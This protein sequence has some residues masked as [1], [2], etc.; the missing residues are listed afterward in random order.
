MWI[1]AKKLAKQ[2]SAF[3][4]VEL[5]LV[6]GT[7]AVV[8]GALV[9]L[10]SNSYEDWK[11]GSNRSTLLQDGQAT[12]EQMVRILRQAKGFSAV[13][14]PTDTAG[15]ITFIDVDG[16]L[17][18]FRLANSTNELQYGEPASLSTLAGSVSSLVF[19]SYD[20]DANS[21][22]DPVQARKIR[23]VHITTTLVDPDN[24]SLM[25]TLSGMVFCQEDFLNDIAINEIMYNPPGGGDAP[26][27][28]V[29]IYNLGDSVVDT[30]GWSINGDTL[31]SHS[32]FGDGSTTIPA[33]GYAVITSSTTNIYTELI[34]NGGF[35][36]ILK[37]YWQV[38]NWSRTKFNAH[39]GSYKLES[40]VSGAAWVYQDI[41]I[42]T[43][44][45][46]YL[47]LF[48]ERTTSAIAQTQIT[49]TVRNLS[50]VI[51][52]TGYGG[53]MNS[54]W[55]CH[56]MDISAFAGQTVRIY[57]STTNNGSGSLLLDDVSVAYS[58]VDINATRL[59]TGDGQ[60]GSGLSDSTDTVTVSSGSSTVD[61][62]TYDDAWGGDGDGT[63]LSRIDPQG[64]SN[65]QN[66]WTSGPVNGTPGSAN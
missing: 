55:T 44:Y 41:T 66:N 24:S 28:W 13:S 53:Q 39:S 27:E 49:V 9:G 20:V 12:I 40:T 46:S 6:V 59:S 52:A 32:Q 2:P 48:W 33:G 21:L 19:T 61:S 43:G 5:I 1:E 25:F 42:P 57:F 54:S 34:T 4:L 31:I 62:V 63:S 65:D 18:E 30:N 26:K 45:N 29:E 64:S 23:A 36:A 22:A 56:T 3:T 10:I 14:S 7:I 11:L 37:A 17:K 51:L 60:I 8:A 38:N 15:Y 47:F 58:Y 50:N 35:E 16:Q